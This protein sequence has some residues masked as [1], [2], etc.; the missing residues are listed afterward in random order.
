MRQIKGAFDVTGFLVRKDNSGPTDKKGKR[1]MLELEFSITIEKEC[2]TNP[3]SK[4]KRK[5]T[6]DQLKAAQAG[7]GG[8]PAEWWGQWEK[9][10]DLP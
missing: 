1:S 9:N 10:R 4:E 2:N 5:G 8:G 7:G 3:E 6:S